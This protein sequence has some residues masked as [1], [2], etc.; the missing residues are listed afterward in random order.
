[1]LLGLLSDPHAN[2][3]ALEAVLA[4]VQRVA[5]DVLVCLGD[6]V[7]YGAQPNEVVAALRDRC[8][9]NL[10]GNHDLAALGDLDPG[11]FNPLAAEALMWTAERLKPE[12]TAFLR[13]LSPTG[14]IEGLDL[15]HASPRN[16]VEEYVIDRFV[17]ERNFAERAFSVVAVG[18]THVPA[19]FLTDGTHIGWVH[20]EPDEPLDLHGVRAIVNP[21]GIGQPRDG[22]PRASWATWDTDHARFVLRRVAYPVEESQQAILEAGLPAPLAHR[23]ARGQ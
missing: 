12:T 20:P 1:V 15:A 7:D 13:S 6:Y 2:L 11:L 23:L 22:D 17:A 21:G 3:P 8:A 10:C 16:P 9:V 19:V 14:A 5:P 18:H 4:D